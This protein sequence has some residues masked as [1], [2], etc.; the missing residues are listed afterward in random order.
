M[1]A[2]HIK[3]GQVLRPIDALKR[4]SHLRNSTVKYKLIFSRRRPWRRRHRCLRS[5]VSVGELIK[6]SDI[7]ILISLFIW[8]FNVR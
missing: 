6:S 5:L 1:L 3:L 2:L 4:S 8:F 7:A